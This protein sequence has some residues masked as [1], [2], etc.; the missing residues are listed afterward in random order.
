MHSYL[1]DGV[2]GVVLRGD[3]RDAPVLALLLRLDDL[4]YF[5]V[6]ILELV[7]VVKCAGKAVSKKQEA[8]H[9]NPNVTNDVATSKISKERTSMSQEGR[10]IDM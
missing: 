4:V 7:R 5:R 9:S 10:W 6:E 2:R 1:G 8:T 3:E